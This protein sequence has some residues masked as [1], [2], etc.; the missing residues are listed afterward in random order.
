MD[1]IMDRFKIRVK[2]K[3]ISTTEDTESTERELFTIQQRTGAA[4]AEGKLTTI[5]HQGGCD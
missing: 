2:V 3:K 5:E 4:R 1:S